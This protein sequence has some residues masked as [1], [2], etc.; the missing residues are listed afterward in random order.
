MNLL[1]QRSLKD[2]LPCVH[3]VE[4]ALYQFLNLLD[5]RQFLDTRDDVLNNSRKT[6]PLNF[7]NVEFCVHYREIRM[8]VNLISGI[9]NA[10][11]QSQHVCR[12]A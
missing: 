3:I 10:L 9:S 1:G 5:V 12:Y 6:L 2:L 11:M 4:R 8:R 7:V